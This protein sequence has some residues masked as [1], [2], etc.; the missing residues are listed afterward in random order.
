MNVSPSI[1]NLRNLSTNSSN[2][3]TNSSFLVL[4]CHSLVLIRQLLGAAGE[5]LALDRQPPAPQAPP[6]PPQHDRGTAFGVNIL[7]HKHCIL[8]RCSIY[9]SLYDTS[10]L[11][12]APQ[13]H[14]GAMSSSPAVYLGSLLPEH[15]VDLSLWLPGEVDLD[16]IF[17]FAVKSS[18][19]MLGGARLWVGG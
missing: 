1:G 13:P 10:H 17:R 6:A 3:G 16:E 11:H 19:L 18:L 5:R 9:F 4:I 2:F 12:P 15:P 7:H 14:C 8:H